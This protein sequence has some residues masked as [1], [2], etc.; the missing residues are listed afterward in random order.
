M[1]I[2]DLRDNIQKAIAVSQ[3]PFAVV[4]TY[5]TTNAGALDEVDEVQ[6][7]CEEFNLWHHIDAVY[8]GAVILSESQQHLWPNF[9]KADSLSFNP[10]KWMFVS[11]TCSLLLFN[12]FSQLEKHFRIAAPYVSENEETNWGEYGI[13]GSRHTSVLKLWLSLYLI[14]KDSYGKLID[15]NFSITRQFATFITQHEQLEMYT[16]PDLNIILFRPR[17]ENGQN[18]QQH[19]E[20]TKKFQNY[21]YK[22]QLYVS[23]IVWKGTTWLK[24]I[25]LNPYFDQTKLDQ[26]IRLIEKYFVS[27]G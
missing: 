25:F 13:Q 20:A 9:A 27:R 7:V 22:Q 18:R 15:L 23:P 5:G 12:Q 14:G 1:H 2:S 16:E 10:Q 8:G 4:S 11:K 17:Q 6:K 24:C 26:L 3:M 19:A 21:L